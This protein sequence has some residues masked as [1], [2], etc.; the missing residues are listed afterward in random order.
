MGAPLRSS[1]SLGAR[2]AGSSTFR[3]WE[4]ARFIS[5]ACAPG[6]WGN[7][8][9]VHYRGVCGTGLGLRTPA[10][11][12]TAG[13]LAAY[14]LGGGR[15]LRDGARQSAV[16]S[17]LLRGLN[18]R[19]RRE[20]GDDRRRRARLRCRPRPSARR[21]RARISMSC[22]RWPPMG[23]RISEGSRSRPSPGPPEAF[24]E[25]RAASACH[26]Q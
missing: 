3:L 20:R 15:V 9:R 4:S 19:G 14:R 2:C 1:A 6:G 12:G 5:T 13:A 26:P 22:L 17:R 8:L 11:G 21:S 7:S 10:G 16:G 24:A 25:S 23:S 18:R